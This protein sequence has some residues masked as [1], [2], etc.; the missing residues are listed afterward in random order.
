MPQQGQRGQGGQR[1][2]GD[3]EGGRGSAASRP[4]TLHFEHDMATGKTSMIE[5]YP[6]EPRRPAW[7]SFSPDRKIVVFAR[8]HNLFMMDAEN[9]EKARKSA[10]DTTI[11]EHQLTTDGEE[12]YSYAGGGRGQGGQQQQQQQQQEE[13]EQQDQEQQGEDAKNQRARPVN[14]VWAPD[15]SRF[16]L[17]RRDAR[18][19]KDLWVIDALGNTASDARD[20]SLRDAGRGAHPAGRDVG[21]R[22]GRRGSA[23]GSRGSASRTRRCRLRRRRRRRSGVTRGRPGSGGLAQPS[24]PASCIFTRLSRDMHKLDV[25]VAD[26]ATGEVTTL[27]EER[28]NT[29]IE[30]RPLRLA[31]NGDELLF[32]SER[33]GWA[34]Y[35]LYDA[36]TGRA[37]EPAHGRGVRRDRHRQHRRQGARGVLHGRRTREG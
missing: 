35:Y 28:L 11:V 13:Q 7:A 30:T 27:I 2:T 36:A 8:N 31:A 20:L 5:D 37:E 21:V 22:R 33:D 3:G 18:L 24:H 25:C 19:V 9:F 1:G 34:H 32:W 15:S 23:S 4:R 29:Y 10:T 16:A 26:T 17:V 12:H 14:L 6:E